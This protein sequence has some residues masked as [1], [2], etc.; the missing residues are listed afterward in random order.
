M[1]IITTRLNGVSVKNKFVEK[2]EGMNFLRSIIAA[3]CFIVSMQFASA[4]SNYVTHTL[5]QGETLS[6]LAKQYNTTVGDIMRL[7]GMHADTKLAYGSPIKIPSTKAQAQAAK[8][9]STVAATA[10]A[11]QQPATSSTEI[12][13]IV[14]KGETLYSI[15]KKYNITVEQIKKWNHLSD[16][17]AKVGTLLIIN[18]NGT[19]KF[20][21][22]SSPQQ[23]TTTAAIPATT[24]DATTTLPAQAAVVASTI[25]QP[26]SNTPAN[27][28]A[29]QNT[30]PLAAEQ[31][32]T[33]AQTNTNTQQADQP[34]SNY[35]GDGY[36]SSQF[37][38]KKKKD[39][40]SV[41]G[42]SKTFKTA[43][44]WT[45]GKYY[46]LVNDIEPG[47]IVK[48]TADNGN[49]V[50]AKVL[51]N[52]GDLKDNAGIDFRVSSAT[53]AALKENDASFG[54]NISF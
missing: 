46:I 29:Q 39:M 9:T 10:P 12:T 25:S 22:T 24:T 36:F 49:T 42:I 50:Y 43:S 40:K 48:L 54:L 21:A 7:N 52:M 14:A 8:K 6:M 19:N 28:P 37:Q 1:L 51:W 26:P 44:G 4:Q 38:E 16:D 11:P 34:A 41:S 45:D 18:E 23:T 13:H 17:N 20:T 35:T 27:I 33:A 2:F 32:Q 30:A 5:K 47:T 31:T 3:V 15:S 53:A